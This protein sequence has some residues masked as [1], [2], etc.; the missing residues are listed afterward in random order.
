MFLNKIVKTFR[1]MENLLNIAAVHTE[2]LP[3][4]GMFDST[5]PSSNLLHIS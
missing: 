4:S 2:T 1:N 3:V 5:P